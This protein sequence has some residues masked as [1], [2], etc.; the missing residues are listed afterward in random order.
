MAL[1]PMYLESL[2]TYEH[3]AGSDS[4]FRQAL[5]H[6][7]LREHFPK[8]PIESLKSEALRVAIVRDTEILEI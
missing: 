3:F 5:D 8:R 2:R 6:F 7:H 1:S 4:L